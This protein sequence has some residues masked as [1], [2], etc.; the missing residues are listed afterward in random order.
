MSERHELAEGDRVEVLCLVD[1]VVD[2]LLVSTDVAKWAPIRLKDS[3]F[4]AAELMASGRALEGRS[5]VR[6]GDAWE[7]I[8]SSVGTKYVL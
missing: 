8:Q 6:G 1:N 3:L 2:G 5:R 7:F 4:D